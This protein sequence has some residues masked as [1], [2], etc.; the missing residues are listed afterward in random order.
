MKIAYLVALVMALAVS[1]VGCSKPDPAPVLA[2]SSWRLLAMGEVASLRTV[3]ADPPV[4]LEFLGD[5]A[6]LAGSTGCNGYG[7][8]YEAAGADF[9]TVDVLITERACP[10][11][12]LFER[13]RAYMETL[14]TAHRATLTPGVPLLIIESEDGRALIFGP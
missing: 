2:G 11:P 8:A 7:G 12:A 6:E 14:S 13:E 9:R 5:G 3:A 4:E 1:A 10:T